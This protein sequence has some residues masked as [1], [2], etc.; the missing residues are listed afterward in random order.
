M[1]PPSAPVYLALVHYPILDKEGGIITTSITNLDIHDGGRLS[2]T[3]GVRRYF[4]VTPL[5]E[6]RSLVYRVR[7]HWV[8]GSG[9][10][11]NLSRHQAMS[12]VEPIP[13]L[14]SVVEQ[15][16]DEEGRRPLLIGTSARVVD[17]QK[18]S[19][20][21]LRQRIF[22]QDTPILLVFGTGWGLAPA[23]LPPLDLFL[24][25][26]KGPTSYNHLSVRSAMSIILDRL[27]GNIEEIP[28]L[29]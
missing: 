24:P 14:L 23:L 10:E 6:Q 26:V 5:Y 16:E 11:K 18:I 27:L 12:K 1:N 21:A 20:S 28:S 9:A 15:I 22:H 7:S 17:H 19:F 2:A 29:P 13:D 8:D 4:L 25:P 3:F